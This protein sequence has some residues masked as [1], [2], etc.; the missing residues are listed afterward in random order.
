MNDSLTLNSNKPST[1]IPI[2]KQSKP[3]LT[4]SFSNSNNKLHCLNDQEKEQ[5]IVSRSNQNDDPC[6]ISV[7][8][9]R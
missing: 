8:I 4:E 5:A 3:N 1:K 2:F 6:K 7:S 9:C